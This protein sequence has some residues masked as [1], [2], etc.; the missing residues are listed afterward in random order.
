MDR[1]VELIL[2]GDQ[3]TIVTPEN[4]RQRDLNL[5]RSRCC[6][7][8]VHPGGFVVKTE[9]GLGIPSVAV[10]TLGARCGDPARRQCGH[11]KRHACPAISP[12]TITGW[13]LMMSRN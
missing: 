2:R 4:A 7:I 1:L 5:E 9:A 3:S 10:Q 12:T 6:A 8:N 13:N 11:I